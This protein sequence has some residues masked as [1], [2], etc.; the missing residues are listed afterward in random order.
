[1]LHYF[2][3]LC[4]LQGQEASRVPRVVMGSRFYTIKLFSNFSN[5]ELNGL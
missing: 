3:P 2:A 4:V 5:L 1:M